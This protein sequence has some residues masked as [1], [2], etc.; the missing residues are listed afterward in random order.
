M[1][2]SLDC[3]QDH[4][5]VLYDRGGRTPINDLV[6]PQRVAWNRVRDDI[7]DATVSLAGDS[8]RRNADVLDAIR[9]GRYEMVI[10]RGADRVWEGPCTLLKYGRTTAEITARDVMHYAARTVMHQ[11]W[12][13]AYPNTTTVVARAANILRTELARKEALSPPIN[14]LPYLQEFH[15]TGE[16]RTSAVTQ[17]YQDYVWSHID[18]MA[19]NSGMD[20]SV[21]GRSIMLWD[22]SNPIGYAPTVTQDD[23]LGDIDVSEYGLDLATSYVVTNGQGVYGIAGSNDSYYGEWEMLSN[24]YDETDTGSQP[25]ANEMASQ[26]KRN[27]AGRNPAP[28]R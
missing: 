20:Y 6:R 4:H 1:S 12:S 2:V 28:V 27:L 24:P 26:A 14:V 13:N 21:L 8:C 5:V 25:T 7:S 10:F 19:E 18:G 9:T 16:A 23:F 11:K 22:T 15:F 3:V 17:K